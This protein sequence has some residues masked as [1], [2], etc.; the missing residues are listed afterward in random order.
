MMRSF[1][2]SLTIFCAIS[3]TGLALKCLECIQKNSDTCHGVSVECP[4][5]AECLVVSEFYHYGSSIYHSIKRSC[6][7]GV[8]CNTSQY[9]SNFINIKLAAYLHCCTG[10]NCNTDNYQMP[11]EEEEHNGRLCTSCYIDELKECV[12]DHTI[13]CLNEEDK[14]VD[15]IGRF[16]DPGNNI[17]EYN[18]KGCISP[19]ACTLKYEGII[20]LQEIQ[21]DKFECSD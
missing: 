14:C 9:S 18:M 17:L 3:C 15:F 7:P 1:I 21:T 20:G 8:P 11:P 6:N 16:L 2:I 10:D 5:S 13:K 4:N 12:S 19:L